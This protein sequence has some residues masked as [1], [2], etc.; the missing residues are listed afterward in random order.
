MV[1]ADGTSADRTQI[2]EKTR[3]SRRGAR[4]F[5][6]GALRRRIVYGGR[7]HIGGFGARRNIG[8]DT[9]GDAETETDER[10]EHEALISR[11]AEEYIRERSH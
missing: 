10:D 5:V 3:R 1:R 7:R 6:G 4:D 11:L 9:D 2:A 8:I